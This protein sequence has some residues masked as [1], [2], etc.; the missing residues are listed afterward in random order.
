MSNKAN[1]A[2]AMRTIRTICSDNRNTVYFVPMGSIESVAADYLGHEISSGDVDRWRRARDPQHPYK[3]YVSVLARDKIL[4]GF[5]HVFQSRETV[6]SVSGLITS[7]SWGADVIGNGALEIPVAARGELSIVHTMAANNLRQLP[8]VEAVGD[9][10]KALGVHKKL[11]GA[12][13][14]TEFRG[15]DEDALSLVNLARECKTAQEQMEQNDRLLVSALVL[16]GAI[17][18]EEM[19]MTI[20]PYDFPVIV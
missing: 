20:T 15:I 2:I 14:V 5:I 4:A 9:Y 3:L 19:G 6:E 8:K 18:A 17:P 16:E 7:F 13:L 11:I 10:W 1:T 12:F